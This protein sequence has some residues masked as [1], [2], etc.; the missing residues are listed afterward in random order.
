MCFESVHETLKAFNDWSLS[1]AV[2][3]DP[4]VE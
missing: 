3:S 4:T 1:A 2:G